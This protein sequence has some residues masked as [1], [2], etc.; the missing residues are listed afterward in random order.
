MA[1][2]TVLNYQINLSR[3]IGI[4]EFDKFRYYER[5]LENSL[6][7]FN[8]RL[9]KYNI[10]DHLVTLKTV[11][12]L[13]YHLRDLVNNFLFLHDGLLQN[14]KLIENLLHDNYLIISEIL[15]QTVNSTI[16][17]IR[18]I[19]D[20]H[21]NF[22]RPLWLNDG[23]A[24]HID[25]VQWAGSDRHKQGHEVLIV[26]LRN[27]D[28]L[29][30][31]VY[32]P[33]PLEIS[34]LLFGKLALLKSRCKGFDTY[35]M[36]SFFSQ[37]E[38]VYG[39]VRNNH[40]MA[41]TYV[42]VPRVGTSY[43]KGD[44][45]NHYGYTE[46]LSNMSEL[47]NNYPHI[48]KIK[49]CLPH[50]LLTQIEIIDSRLVLPEEAA[51]RYFS[52]FNNNA[53]A[54]IIIKYAKQYIALNESVGS[55]IIYCL[56]D[57]KVNSKKEKLDLSDKIKIAKFL[58]TKFN[59]FTDK[60]PELVCK[61]FDKLN[62]SALNHFVT[63]NFQEMEGF[64][65]HAGRL[66]G[67]MFF[68]GTNDGH[69]EN[70]MVHNK[71][72]YLIDSETSLSF[73][74]SKAKNLTCLDEMTGNAGMI[75]M[76]NIKTPICGGLLFRHF[77]PNTLFYFNGWQ[78][79]VNGMRGRATECFMQGVDL[80]IEA[81]RQGFFENTVLESL[82]RIN[83]GNA[84]LY[85]RH[86][87]LP[88]KLYI[89][90]MQ[91]TIRKSV[92]F[93]PANTRDQ[94]IVSWQKDNIRNALGIFQGTYNA[95]AR[96]DNATEDDET[97]TDNRHFHREKYILFP[98]WSTIKCD[99]FSELCHMNIPVYYASIFDGILVDFNS[100]PIVRNQSRL[101]LEQFQIRLE[102]MEALDRN[103]HQGE[104]LF[105]QRLSTA[106]ATEE[107]LAQSVDYFPQ[108]PIEYLREKYEF[109]NP[110]DVHDFQQQCLLLAGNIFQRDIVLSG[111]MLDNNPVEGANRP[112]HRRLGFGM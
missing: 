104:I 35:P 36:D 66:F 72:F 19:R 5:F 25:S 26:S 46:F 52:R 39:G 110:R 1:I 49:E 41:S 22:I 87:P 6:S 54:V 53:K 94:E 99:V 48:K 29:R 64:W 96:Y 33:N 23:D 75:P 12:N 13:I 32:K 78:R 83:N 93:K 15:K 40:D 76:N 69:N 24:I 21:D 50:L 79:D 85:V 42:I 71:R 65:E 98:V 2:V 58:S 47:Y 103:L 89:D 97:V 86:T 16:I 105:L 59:D 4:I 95:N 90:Y 10:G 61:E 31:I 108:S 81:F 60:F 14:P 56:E 74:V 30:K 100:R 27:G 43:R 92:M 44:V 20:D 106:I 88:T 91:S 107:A 3:R 77:P 82:R 70:L 45:R 84:S 102:R 28:N 11:D 101:L 7:Y 9:N 63:D 111:Q 37:F 67:F 112:V 55:N 62:Q 38:V 17:A 73:K 109:L 34:A 80:A 18:R 8:S 51:N 57:Y 68:I